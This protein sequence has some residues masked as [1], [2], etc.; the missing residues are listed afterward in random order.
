MFSTNPFS[1]LSETVPL[2]GIQSFVVVM[3]A[4]VIL[5][6]VLDMIHKKNVKYFFN[7]AKKA[8]KS[9][10]RELGT[11]ERLAVIGKTIIHD[12]GTTAEL[13]WGK[14]RIAHVLGMYGTIFFWIGSA[15]MIFFYT[16]SQTPKVLS[17]IH[18]SSPRDT[19]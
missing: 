14:R 11:S 19:A 18:I 15:A 3:V 9:A 13:G 5:G 7:N 17:L 10:K 8:K 12:I 1:I 6:T 16:D 4:L 2:I